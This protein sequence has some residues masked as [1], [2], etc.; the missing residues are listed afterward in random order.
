MSLV[1]FSGHYSPFPAQS[2]YISEFIIKV[3]ISGMERGIFSK[4]EACLKA[5]DYYVQGQLYCEEIER[6]S[7]WA[8]EPETP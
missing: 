6:V 8:K 4:E 3:L 5:V 7:L 1:D 2:P